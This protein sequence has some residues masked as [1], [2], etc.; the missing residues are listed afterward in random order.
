M[1]D[2]VIAKLMTGRVTP[3][4]VPTTPGLGAFNAVAGG[5]WALARP[6]LRRG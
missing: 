4:G 1:P 2:G 3:S 5:Y 6:L